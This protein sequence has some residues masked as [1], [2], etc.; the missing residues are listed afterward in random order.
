MSKTFVIADTHFGDDN[1]RKFENRPFDT[2]IQMTRGL[3]ERWNETV[4]END[5]VYV[6]GDFCVESEIKT[7]LAENKLNGKIILIVGNHDKGFEDEYRKYDVEVIEHPIILDGFWILSHEPMYVSE[8]TPYANVFGH[9]HNNP[10]YKT[11][12]SRSYCV[13]VERIGYR[14][15]EFSEVKKAVLEFQPF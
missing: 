7:V 13:S 6:L 1:I 14:P 10:M 5:T 15:I 3:I 2:V 9:V 11:V 4:S 8:Q 12:S